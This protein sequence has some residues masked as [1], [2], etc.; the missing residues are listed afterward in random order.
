MGKI[1]TALSVF[2]CRVT[3]VI[4]F[5]KGKTG[6]GKEGNVMHKEVVEARRE[7]KWKKNEKK[8]GLVQ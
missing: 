2:T 6:G 5:G 1:C 3:A 8:N 7:K 4:L